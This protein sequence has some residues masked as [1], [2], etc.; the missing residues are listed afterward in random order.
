[1][2]INLNIITYNTYLAFSDSNLLYKLRFN[3]NNLAETYKYYFNKITIL[4]RW[5]LNIQFINMTGL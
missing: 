2:K 4:R 3:S 1:M 5:N